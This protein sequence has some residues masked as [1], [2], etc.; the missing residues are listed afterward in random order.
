MEV[1][2]QRI[3]RSVR[4]QDGKM[5]VALNDT[6]IN[7][8]GAED[9]INAT[10]TGRWQEEESVDTEVPA[11]LPRASRIGERN[12]SSVVWPL[13]PLKRLPPRRACA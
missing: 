12:E 5:N 10:T 8:R 4:D 9:W 1:S 13:F 6:A 2:G 3:T 7:V 11:R